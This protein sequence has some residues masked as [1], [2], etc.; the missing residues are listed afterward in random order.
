MNTEIGGQFKWHLMATIVAGIVV[1][2]PYFVFQI[3]KFVQPALNLKEKKFL[4]W[5]SVITSGLF[6]LGILFGYY[7][8]LPLTLAFLSNYQISAQIEN[9]ITL[10]SYLSTTV[11]L[12]LTIGLVFELPLLVYFLSKIGFITSALMRKFRKHAIV[13]ILIV[14]GI[15]TPSTD[16]FSQLLVAF[17]LYLLYE[18]SIWVA[19]RNEMGE[20]KLQ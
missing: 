1:S 4:R 18:V 20:E 11:F 13:L 2:F 12:P 14:A 19:R 9:H 16:V 6:F 15:I 3:W 8:V 10:A 17:P 5:F 7:V